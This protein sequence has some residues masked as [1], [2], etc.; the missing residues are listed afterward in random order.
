VI[1]ERTALLMRPLGTR[2]ARL[3]RSA[4][5]VLSLVVSAMGRQSLRQPLAEAM[6]GI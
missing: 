5:K 2:C 6:G 4:P 1:A 3:M